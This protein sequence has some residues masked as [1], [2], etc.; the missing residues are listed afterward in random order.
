MEWVNQ[1]G[2]KVVENEVEANIQFIVESHGAVPS[3]NHLSTTKYVSSH[4]IR[5]CLMVCIYSALSFD[6][7]YFRCCL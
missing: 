5:S 2:G 7:L 3:K 1:G 4:W 6:S